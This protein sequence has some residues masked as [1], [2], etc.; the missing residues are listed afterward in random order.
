MRGTEITLM[1]EGEPALT[2][3][4]ACSVTDCPVRYDTSHGYF[5]AK[6]CVLMERDMTPRHTCPHHRQFMYLAETNLEEGAFACGD[7]RDAMRHGRT[8]NAW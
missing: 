6:E 5:I 3:T 1:I 7:A 4:Y 8:A 2:P